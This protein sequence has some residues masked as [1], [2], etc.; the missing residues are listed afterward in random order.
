MIDSDSDDERNGIIKCPICFNKFTNSQPFA[1]I[2]NTSEKGKY[3]IECIEKWLD[4]SHNGL[5]T[6]DKVLSYSIYH[7]NTLIE[8]IPVS[9]IIKNTD[10]DTS[11]NFIDETIITFD[12]NEDNNYD[13]KTVYVG[14]GIVI[15]ILILVII[16]IILL[17]SI[18]FS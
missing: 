1:M 4:I 3:C 13:Y 16:I 5:L 11:I 6:Q 12:D 10:T 14:G 18:K 8:T 7:E 17:N 9:T 15:I 2:D